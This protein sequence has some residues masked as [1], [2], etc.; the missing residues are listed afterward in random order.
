MGLDTANIIGLSIAGAVFLG[1]VLITIIYWY[2]SKKKKTGTK[3][4]DSYV[5][6][7]EPSMKLSD[8]LEQ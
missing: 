5:S 1:I 4:S 2:R 6:G 7:I 3:K 8:Y